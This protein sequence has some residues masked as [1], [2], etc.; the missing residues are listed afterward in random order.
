[1]MLVGLETCTELDPGPPVAP[2]RGT[3]TRLYYPNLPFLH[4]HSSIWESVRPKGVPAPPP[5]PSCL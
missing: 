3:S 4:I 2:F 5:L 1:M